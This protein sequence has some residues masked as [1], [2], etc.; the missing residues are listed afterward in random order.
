LQWFGIESVLD[1][2]TRTKLEQVM[3]V[4]IATWSEALLAVEFSSENTPLP[5]TAGGAS[6]EDPKPHPPSNRA[7]D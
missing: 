7:R 6:R 2:T 5:R 4:Y 3:G 1:K